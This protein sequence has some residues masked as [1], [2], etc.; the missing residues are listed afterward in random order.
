MPNCSENNFPGMLLHGSFDPRTGRRET[1]RCSECLT[2]YASREFL[3]S[4][5]IKNHPRIHVAMPEATVLDLSTPKSRSRR[6]G[7]NHPPPLHSSRPHSSPRPQQQQ[8]QQQQQQPSPRK[9]PCP[10][11]SQAQ[12]EEGV[13]EEGVVMEGGGSGGLD[14]ECYCTKCKREYCSKYFLRTHLKKEHQMTTEQYLEEV[15]LVYPD[16]WQQYMTPP[17]GMDASVIVSASGGS[18]SRRNWCR[19]CKKDFCNKY[20]FKT[21]MQKMH[22]EVISP[23]ASHRS[24]KKRSKGVPCDICNKHLCSKYFLRIHKRNTHGIVDPTLDSVEPHGSPSFVPSM[25]RLPS[26]NSGSFSGDEREEE[27]MDSTSTPRTTHSM[28]VDEEEEEMTVRPTVI[29]SAGT[30][31]IH[32]ASLNQGDDRSPELEGQS[33][34]VGS[35]RSLSPAA[36]GPCRVTGLLSTPVHHG[37]HNTHVNAVLGNLFVVSIY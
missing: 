7:E 9:R 6:S 29:T 13:M 14:L 37:T 17:G 22:N 26:F 10:P 33:D 36:L 12:P 11:P 15:R 21:H 27:R 5:L 16:V 2:D 23:I 1:F 24:A 32:P 25:S 18:N 28:F 19:W 8:Q 34:D 3:E 30:H 4:H 20:F 35:N 31:L